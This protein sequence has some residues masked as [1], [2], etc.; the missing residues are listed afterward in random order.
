MAN[1]FT[2]F[3]KVCNRLLTIIELTR[4]GLIPTPPITA[5]PEHPGSRGSF[6][7]RQAW[8]MAAS[9]RTRRREAWGFQNSRGI[10]CVS[11][12]EE[13]GEGGEEGREVRERS[14]RET[15]Q[16]GETIR[17]GGISVQPRNDRLKFLVLRLEK[18]NASPPP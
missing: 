13:G 1:P 6:A 2:F 11:V 18:K 17:L 9:H 14:W 16:H 5:T 15:E 8:G 3:K 10:V 7:N 12:R 4:K